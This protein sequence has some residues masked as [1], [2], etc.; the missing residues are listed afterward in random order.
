MCK[1]QPPLKLKKK[2][3]KTSFLRKTSDLP[4]PIY[5]NKVPLREVCKSRNTGSIS[6]VESENVFK[7]FTWL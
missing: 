2:V 6:L 4:D 1:E 7:Q 5:R 3:K